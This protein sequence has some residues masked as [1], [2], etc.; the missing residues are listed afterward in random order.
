MKM[1]I[2]VPTRGRP[3]NAQRLYEAIER[4]S[5]ADVIFCVDD[6]D[7]R[8]DDY[9]A[10]SY[11]LYVGPRRRLVGTL[12]FVSQHYLD[13][14]DIIGF[15][16]DDTLPKTYRW[17]LKIAGNFQNNMIAYANDGHQKE[18][19]PTGVFLD[20][21]IIRVLG[22]M[23]PPTFIHLFADNFWKTLGESL[24][25][26]QYFPDVDIEHLHPYAGKAEH[27][28]TYEEANTGAVWVNDEIAFHNYVENLLES[29][30][31]K[32]NA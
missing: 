28:Q 13:D 1:I 12:N 6:D 18:G 30:V 14:Y 2:I 11:P 17:D 19:L 24:G 21:N 5:D 26:L 15:L 25:T 22:Y 9:R 4:T 8:L 29:D 23:V 31:R 16:G 20:S 27:D 10:G 3:E 32:L 7:R